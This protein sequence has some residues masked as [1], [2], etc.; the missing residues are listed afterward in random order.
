MSTGADGGVEDDGAVNTKELV[1]DHADT[2]E[3]FAASRACT[4][5][6]QVPVPSVGVQEVP[7]IQPDEEL[8]D[9][10]ALLEL[11]CTEY[12]TP[13]PFELLDGFHNSWI[14]Q[15]PVQVPSVSAISTG[16]VGPLEDGG[17]DDRVKE[18]AVDQS[19]TVVVF[20]ESRT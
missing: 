11:T 1:A 4:R 9:E 5:Q 13:F 20:K 16:T 15:D 19:E 7:L 2:S 3:V 17:V 12:C 8:T 6:Y 14:P 10:K 18:P